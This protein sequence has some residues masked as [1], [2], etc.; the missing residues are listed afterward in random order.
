[1]AKT[2]MLYMED[3]HVQSFEAKVLS[4]DENYVVLD[5]T[6]FYP[7]GGGQECDNGTLSFDNHVITISKVKRE[8]GEVRHYL[9]DFEK[10]PVKGDVV[11][12]NLDW[13]RRFTHMKYHTAIH[14]LSSYMK[15]HY[16]SECVGN[17]ISIRNGRADFNLMSSLTEEDLTKIEKGINEIIAK[18][19]P[20]QITFMPREDAIKYLEE[21]GYQTDY[22]EMVPKSVKTF[23]VISVDD[24]DHASCA[25][26]HVKNTSEIGKVK[27][28]K[29][30]SMG[31][32]KERITLSFEEN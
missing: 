19:L 29:R 32:G 13:E 1:M 2:K 24:Y 18:N 30:R 14:V 16:N 5:R 11:N 7:E 15:E 3:N 27:V 10:L 20:V 21:K 28:V 17:N 23:R 8:S 6:A 25:G 22:I 12:C 9:E 31:K 26:T 4:A